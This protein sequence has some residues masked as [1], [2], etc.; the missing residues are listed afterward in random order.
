MRQEDSPKKCITLRVD[1]KPSSLSYK[2]VWLDHL[3]M[4]SWNIPSPE[5]IYLE[6][7]V[8]PNSSLGRRLR[9]VNGR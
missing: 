3:I 6:L 9:V 2:T 8:F 4:V 7:F 5:L 1:G